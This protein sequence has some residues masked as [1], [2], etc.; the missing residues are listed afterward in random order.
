[1][2][3]GNGQFLVV[4][5]E[6]GK[7]ILVRGKDYL[8]K[9]SVGYTEKSLIE[10]KPELIKFSAKKQVIANLGLF[11]AYGSAYGCR[12]E[13]WVKNIPTKN[14][15]DI[16]QFVVLDAPFEN[17]VLKSLWRTRSLLKEHGVSGLE[18]GLELRPPKGKYAGWYKSGK[19]EHTMCVMPKSDW[20]N[21]ELDYVFAHEHGHAWWYQ[22]MGEKRRL[23]WVRKY[24][25]L[26]SV[27]ETFDKELKQMLE[28]AQ[29]VGDLRSYA[30]EL[31]EDGKSVLK[32]I[33]QHVK[34]IYKISPVHL[35]L[36]VLNQEDI[37]HLWPTVTQ[38]GKPEVHLTE[39]ATVSPE[40]LFAEAF[41]F[42]VMGKKIPKDLIELVEKSLK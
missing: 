20:E 15:G 30:K 22:K 39:Y 19:G 27:R 33:Y 5:K 21:D 28:D 42:Y 18:F 31:D 32:S 24:H 13:P 35:N 23:R 11:P 6:D 3:F 8:G 29:A 9:S 2:K 14:M 25:K 10:G 38:V 4:E 16:K 34:R 12:V 7:R 41:A 37:S 17:R 36:M 40:E 1:M 26:V